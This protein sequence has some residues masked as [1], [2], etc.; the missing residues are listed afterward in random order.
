[1]IISGE[2]RDHIPRRLNT[3]RKMYF[4]NGVLLSVLCISE[5]IKFHTFSGIL[6][7]LF[8]K[9][10]ILGAIF[11]FVFT[12]K[13]LPTGIHTLGLLY[14][15]FA[16]FQL[17]FLSPEEFPL[18]FEIFTLQTGLLLISCTALTGMNRFWSV[19]SIVWILFIYSATIF[20]KGQFGYSYLLLA[21]FIV[22]GI[23]TNGIIQDQYLVEQDMISLVNYWKNYTSQLI[24]DKLPKEFH[25]QNVTCMYVDVSG[26]F[27]YFYEKESLGQVKRTLIEFIKKFKEEKQNF[28]ILE[29][30]ETGHYW[31]Y[32]TENPAGTDSTYADPL[33]EFAIKIRDYFEELC[34]KRGLKFSLRIGMHSGKM[35]DYMYD[36]K[37]SLLKVFR[38]E[39]VFE[40]A[41]QMEKEGINGE[42]QVTNDT[43]MLLKKNFY[44]T[45]RDMYS[46]KEA[47]EGYYILNRKKEV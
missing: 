22:I 14:T 32:I 44:L 11:L 13:N 17:D 10:L 27:S 30:D 9:I 19:V 38:S 34:K 7:I 16:G 24:S 36:P 8:L 2:Y 31:F 4:S 37:N 47:E 28:E 25:I 23:S 12:G 1:M 42:I 39:L 29:L 3:L 21:V 43:Y 40:R 20:V 41:K 15:V 5:F 46:G 18:N 33:A 26:I 45:R 35:T 6:F